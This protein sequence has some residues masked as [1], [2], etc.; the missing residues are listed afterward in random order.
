M[1]KT[2]LQ[3]STF[4][5]DND[6]SDELKYIAKK[7]NV[8][9]YVILL[10]AFKILLFRRSG[11][12]DLNVATP[13]SAFS[14]LRT[15][16]TSL[17]NDETFDSLLQRMKEIIRQAYLN[18]EITFEEKAKS[19]SNKKSL[20]NSLYQF[21]FVLQNFAEEELNR[22]KFDETASRFGLT[23]SIT[24]TSDHLEGLIVYSRDTISEASV[25]QME[26]HYTHLLQS[27]V[28]QE[29]QRIGEL[30]ILTDEENVLLKGFNNTVTEYPKEKTIIDLFEQ[31]ADAN[32]EAVAIIFKDDKLTYR[33]LNEKANQ[34]AWYL[35]AKGV[36]EET[37]L[38]ICLDRSIEMIV[39]ILATWKAGAAYVP[40]DPGSPNTRIDYVLKDTNASLML[41]DSDHIEKLGKTFGHFDTISVNGDPKILEQFSKSNLT[42]RPSPTHLAYVIYTSGSTGKPK[43]VM[44]EHKSV[45][46]YILNSKRKF[47]SEND[48]NSGA[49]V[50]LSYT[51]DAS[52]KSIFTPLISGKLIVISSKQLFGVFED[53]NLHKYAPYDFIQ[54]TPSH[55]DFFFRVY[56]DEIGRPITRKISIGGEALYISHFD[57]LIETGEELEVINEYGPTEATVACSS[58]SFNILTDKR[59]SER[60]P[61]GKPID[62]SQMYVL[63][64]YNQPMP[65]GITG[66][67]CVGGV[68]V[69]RGYLNSPDLTKR[70]FIA[71][72]FNH[73]SGSTIYKTGDMGR[74]LPDGNIECLGRK[75][76]Q[77]KIRGHRVE[78][79]EIES[80]L[81]K[82]EMIRQVTVIAKDDN[83]TGKRLVAYIVP[84]GVFNKK[85]IIAYLQI[86]L[87]NYMIPESW[88]IQDRLPLTLTGKIDRAILPEPEFKSAGPDTDRTEGFDAPRTKE[89]Q[90]IA[91][92]W[93]DVLGV[94]QIGINDNFFELGEPSLL[95][96]K[97]LRLVEEMTG[98]YLPLST[99]YENPTLEQFA[100]RIQG[101][102]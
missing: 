82:N 56:K 61:I 102:K 76:D 54:L 48:K 4:R 86:W 25:T 51:F 69:A 52:I 71:D 78:P 87:P 5:I 47:I 55:L 94:Q 68:Q 67:I 72:P 70:K 79:G 81:I 98:K 2:V 100:K 85:E 83:S 74:W 57:S 9:L 80:I 42:N 28:H 88:I 6:L 18:P 93:Q 14:D 35:R 10:A 62:N 95:A 21:M 53:D 43:G 45:F 44:V 16:R 66:E 99:I 1:S 26:G 77:V 96:I 7:Q 29:Q 32:P 90:T 8:S 46:N 39:A 50:H 20:H 3:T 30:S 36:K 33:E 31:Q 23:L 84:N 63:N 91:E 17:N 22:D 58:Y 65:I 37:L 34:L 49:F 59:S 73:T 19:A 101:D 38:P 27:I 89:E 41:S 97:V 11:Q 13:N 40:I 92:I 75:D 15:I 24:Q 64:E 12:Y 60:L